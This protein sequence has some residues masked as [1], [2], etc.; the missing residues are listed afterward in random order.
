MRRRMQVVAGTVVSLCVA[1]LNLRRRWSARTRLWPSTT[2]M[3]VAR[4]SPSCRQFTAITRLP[5][6]A[7][8]PCSALGCV[9]WSIC[10]STP[11]DAPPARHPQLSTRSGANPGMTGLGRPAGEWA[12]TLLP[13]WKCR[14]YNGKPMGRRR[15]FWEGYGKEWGLF[16][17]QGIRDSGPPPKKLA[18][19]P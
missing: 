1:I 2:R 14:R 7:S 19:F 5:A 17:G 6:A 15:M 18:P 13:A 3:P 11:P 8:C 10:P 16:V 4:P 12:G 9:G